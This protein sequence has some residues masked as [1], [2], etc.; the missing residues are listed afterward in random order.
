MIDLFELANQ[1]PEEKKKVGPRSIGRRVGTVI[2][3]TS[4]KRIDAAP[5]VE[6]KKKAVKKEVVVIDRLNYR[7][8]REVE[9]VVDSFTE[10]YVSELLDGVDV[11]NDVEFVNVDNENCTRKILGKFLYAK[12]GSLV[13]DLV[14]LYGADRE[15]CMM[16]SINQLEKFERLYKVRH[17][18]RA[19]LEYG[20][21]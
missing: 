3:R 14:R 4:G 6:R 7:P 21:E 8:L 13:Y 19:N 1:E 5:K 17:D 2:N 10:D 9:V 12:R 15:A 20:E 18:S 11:P 16:A